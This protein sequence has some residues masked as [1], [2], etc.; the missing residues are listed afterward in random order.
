MNLISREG[1]YVECSVAETE[2][3]FKSR[4]DVLCV[5]STVID[6]KT[7]WEVIEWSSIVPCVRG[8]NNIRRVIFVVFG[9]GE[10]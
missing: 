6:K 7:F 4:R 5:E 9:D 3:E 1:R 2:P 10:G 8:E